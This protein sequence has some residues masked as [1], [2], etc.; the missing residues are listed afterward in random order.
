VAR[1][2]VVAYQR[3][4]STRD[5]FYRRVESR[6]LKCAPLGDR[7]NRAPLVASIVA[8]A[9]DQASSTYTVVVT[10]DDDF[11]LDTTTFGNADIVLTGETSC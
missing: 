8:P 3:H 5:S 6:R 10:Y 7:V 2:T 9:V 4:V 11:G 1:R